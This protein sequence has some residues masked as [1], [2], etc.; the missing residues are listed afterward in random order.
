MCSRESWFLSRSEDVGGERVRLLTVCGSVRPPIGVNGRRNGLVSKPLGQHVDVVPCVGTLDHRRGVGVSQVVESDAREPGGCGQFQEAFI[1]S[2][3][4]DGG[5]VAVGPEQ[6]APRCTGRVHERVCPRCPSRESL[7]QLAGAVRPQR[8]QIEYLRF[9]M[10]DC[11]DINGT[12]D[13]SRTD[14]ESAVADEFDGQVELASINHHGSGY[15]NSSAYVDALSPKISVVQTG[16]NSYGHP[17]SAVL[18]RYAE[19]G[20]VFQTQSA[21]NNS[22]IDGRVQIVTDGISEMRITTSEGTDTVV[23]ID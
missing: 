17:S 9:D 12:D 3:G 11:G 7:L 2:V 10:A 18:D 13:G 19:Y 16:K 6:A 23:A 14:V 8:R 1:P 20:L 5:A 4:M 22:P 21:S 15:S